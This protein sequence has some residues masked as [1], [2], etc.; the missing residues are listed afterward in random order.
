M[1]VSKISG[2][3]YLQT[4]NSQSKVK[5]NLHNETINN[6]NNVCFEGKKWAALGAVGWGFLGFIAGG[7]VGA[8]IAATIG[9]GALGTAMDDDD[10]HDPSDTEPPY[11][12]P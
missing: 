9:A 5:K 3:N 8:A 4:C 12:N 2:I 11:Y 10:K 1:N 6:S 7:P